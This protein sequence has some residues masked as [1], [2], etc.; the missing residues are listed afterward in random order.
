MEKQFDQLMLYYNQLKEMALQIAVM[1]EKESYN[2][3]LTML[4]NR[5][6]VVRE[7]GLIERYLQLTS[8]QK[9]IVDNIKKEIRD[10]E[11]KNIQ[12]LQTDMEDVKYELDI[13]SAK[14][15]FRNK[16][17]PYEAEQATGN[18]INIKDN[19]V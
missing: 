17:N 18:V 6:R 19:E 10:I 11:A 3:A 15:K 16:Y 14:V 8:K 4:N 13:V 9:K 1:L 5:K 7:M 12:K 2:E